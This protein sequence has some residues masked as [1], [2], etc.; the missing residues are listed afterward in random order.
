MR[1]RLPNGN[2]D[3]TYKENVSVMGPHLS[4][5]YQTHRPITWEVLNDL[6]QRTMMK[7]LDEPIQW[8]DLIH[9]IAKLSNGK[10][11]ELNEVPPDAC[12]ALNSENLSTL[13][14]F[15]DEFWEGRAD[16]SEWHEGQMVPV[17]KKGDL[18]DPDKWRGITLMG[19]GS[20]LFSSILCTRLFKIIKEHDVKYQFGSTPRVGCP[21]GT[22]T[23]KTLLHLRFNHNLPMWVLFADLIKVLDTLNH[24]LMTEILGKYRCPPKLL[25]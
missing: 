6:R 17:P 16:F 11:P 14:N 20:K 19:M 24:K 13:L 15:L 25:K 1:L 5:V 21:D 18:G 23:I 4:Q 22:V 7:T 8:E 2:L 12:N 9:A 10:A 3:T